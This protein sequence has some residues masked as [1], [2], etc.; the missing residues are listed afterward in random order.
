MKNKIFLLL[1]AAML[2]AG[3]SP[4]LHAQAH[5]EMG[6]EHAHDLHGY[7]TS[8]STADVD[9][10]DDAATGNLHD[11]LHHN[12][13]ESVSFN[14]VGSVAI[15]VTLNERYVGPHAQLLS[16]HSLVPHQPPRLA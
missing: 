11:T 13:A 6:Y 9:D 14:G 2:W 10:H 7:G 5:S 15:Q 4:V 8:G 16:T 1:V 12:Y 3:F